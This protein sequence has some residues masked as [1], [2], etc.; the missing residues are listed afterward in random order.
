M[1]AEASSPSREPSRSGEDGWDGPIFLPGRRPGKGGQG[2]VFFG[3]LRGH[4]RTYP[5]L[6]GKDS[7][8][9]RPTQR[10]DILQALI[11]SHFAVEDWVARE[12]ATH[13]RSKTYQR[14]EVFAALADV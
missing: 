7:V 11:D 2:K 9:I 14:S 12:D 3:K 6:H 4:T 5:F 10:S 8:T 13:A 1:Q